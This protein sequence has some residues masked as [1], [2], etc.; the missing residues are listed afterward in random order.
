MKYLFIVQG[1]GRGHL[2]QAIALSDML[3]NNGHEVT[4]VLVGK[5]KNREIPGFFSKKI[6]AQVSTYETPSFVFSNDKKHINMLK[7]L[8]FNVRPGRLRKYMS[9]IEMIHKKIKKNQPDV[10]VNFYEMLGGLA[11]LRFREEVPFVSVGHQ[12]LT[13]H[14]DYAHG[15]SDEQ[16]M[17][18]M[19]LHTLICSIGACKILALSFY[20]MREYQREHL[21]VVPPLMRKEVTELSPVTG[22]FI[23]GYMVN[24]GYEEEVRRWHE[25]NPDVNLVFFWDK[26][27]AEPVTQVDET[28]VFHYLHDEKFLTFMAGCK[29]Y[30]TT[31]GFESICEALY[32][33]KS[34]ML[35]P[36]H[37]EQEVNAADACAMGGGIIGDSFDLDKLL[38]YMETKQPSGNSFKQWVDAAEE[39]IIK[40][41]TS[42]LWK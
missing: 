41:L 15:K 1:D 4:E 12:F 10:V 37:V 17:M 2:T 20:P 18:F 6:G 13:K 14:P 31:A 42:D 5:S 36:A 32:L 40:H 9:S 34:I 29:G 25:K 23:L 28:L 26:K 39:I 35:I 19:R 16:G 3:R 8:L 11:H 24:Q 33:N 30:I 38:N 27:D 22:N 7:T 21:F